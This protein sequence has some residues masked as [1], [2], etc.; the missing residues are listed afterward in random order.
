MTHPTRP[1]YRLPE[2]FPAL[3]PEVADQRCHGSCTWVWKDG[4]FRLKFPSRACAVH[5]RYLEAER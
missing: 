3:P 4:Q 5:G 1:A 2:Q